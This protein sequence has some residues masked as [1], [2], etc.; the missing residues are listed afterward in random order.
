MNFFLNIF[1]SFFLL[2][3]P[4]LGSLWSIAWGGVRTGARLGGVQVGCSTVLRAQSG[5]SS[6]RVW[7]SE[8]PR[9]C[10]FHILVVSH[11]TCV[12]LCPCVGCVFAVYFLSV[13]NS[14]KKTQ[15]LCFCS[16]LDGWEKG[17]TK[18]MVREHNKKVV[19]EQKR[20]REK[21][22]I[23]KVIW[24]NVEL[25]SNEDWNCPIS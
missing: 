3:F 1:I 5:E 22:R 15:D 10:V 19:R 9:I 24:L 18:N 25:Y 14:H 21:V 8:R 13:S 6:E 7:K 17:Q 12:A 20:R 4:F 11:K 16:P 23:Q 2:H